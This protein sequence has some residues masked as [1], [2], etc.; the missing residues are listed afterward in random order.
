MCARSSQ[1]EMDARGPRQ[2]DKIATSKAD[3]RMTLQN[4]VHVSKD[5]ETMT[6]LC[7]ESVL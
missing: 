6:C 1:E 4:R 7:G 5:A 2:S 3:G